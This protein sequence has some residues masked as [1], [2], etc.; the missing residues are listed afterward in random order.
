MVHISVPGIPW[1]LL[2]SRGLQ[3][4]PLDM[5]TSPD[6]LFPRVPGYL[7]SGVRSTCRVHTHLPHGVGIESLVS[8]HPGMQEG[9]RYYTIYAILYI[10]GITCT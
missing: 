1:H 6:P 4:I 9:A 8:R 10:L 5:V 2:V 3:M 7:P